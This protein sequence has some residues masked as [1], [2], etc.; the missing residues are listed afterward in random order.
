[1]KTRNEPNIVRNT[2]FVGN[3]KAHRYRSMLEYL[4]N[5]D[6]DNILEVGTHK[7]HTGAE[8]IRH[9][10]NT[11]V[12]YYGVDVFLSGWSDIVEREE[13]SIKPDDID[14]VRNF[15][16]A[17]SINVYLYEGRSNDVLPVLKEKNLNFDLIWIDGGHSY[18]TVKND[19]V[20]SIDMLSDDGVIFFDDY[21]EEKSYPPNNPI[22][23]GVKPF[24][25]ELISKNE[26]EITILNDYV[27]EYRGNLYRIVSLKRKK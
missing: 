3:L 22:P 16:S 9:S 25:D 24:I 14:T 20:H 6:C 12:N 5:N 10:K 19:F 1:M 2:F 27:D 17:Y 7:G 8:L 11:N 13:Q 26:Y 23:L 21:T 4:S 15:L 18:E